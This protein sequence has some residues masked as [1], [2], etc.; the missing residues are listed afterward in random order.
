MAGSHDG[1]VRE[2]ASLHSDQVFSRREAIDYGYADQNLTDAVRAGVLHRIR[3]GA[4]AF[5]D[6]WDEASPQGRHQMHAH[7]VLRAHSTALAL[8]HTSAAVEH[9]LRLHR[10]DLAKVHVTCL[11]ARLGRTSR[12]VIYHHTPTSGGDVVEV[13]GYKAIEPVRTGVET[14]MLSDVPSGL[15]VMDSVIALG[16]GDL[17]DIHRAYE[18]VARWPGARHL[19]ITVRLVRSGGNSVG[20]SLSR[21]LFWAHGV[22]A[23]VLQFE[24]RDERGNLVGCT[25]FAWPEYGLLGEFDGKVKYGTLLGP[26]ETSADAVFRE[27][28]RED[29]IRELT[30]WLMVRLVWSDLYEPRRTAER[31]IAQLERARRLSAGRR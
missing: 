28:Q 21:H 19:Q 18:K 20:E 14:A 24:V 27:K 25:D 10:P 23:P 9:G 12:D 16:Y 1:A 2:L 17:D 30:G 26:G 4:Y 7:A 8:S 5:R 31:I 11:G 6:T 22:P 3:Q 15:V 13:N 29:R